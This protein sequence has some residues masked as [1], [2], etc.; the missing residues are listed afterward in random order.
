[1]DLLIDLCLIFASCKIGA[2][3]LKEDE[4]CDINDYI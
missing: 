3:L 1:M 2:Y 4:N